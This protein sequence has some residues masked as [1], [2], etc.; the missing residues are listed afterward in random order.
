MKARY[1]TAEDSARRRLAA[2]YRREAKKHC[3]Q[4]GHTMKR[5]R[6]NGSTPTSYTANCSVCGLKVLANSAGVGGKAPVNRCS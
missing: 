3:D 2:H 6:Q 5:F 4:M 1:E